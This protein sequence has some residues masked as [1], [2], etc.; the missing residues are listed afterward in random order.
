M[1]RTT[2]STAR[3][4]G[5]AVALIAVIGVVTLSTAKAGMLEHRGVDDI[6]GAGLPAATAGTPAA[7]AAS[8]DYSAPLGPPAR[9]AQPPPAQPTPPPAAFVALSNDLNSIVAATGAH[10]GI[11]LVELA[12]TDAEALSINGGDSFYAASEYKLP[13]LEY[14]AEMIAAGQASPDDQICFQD[15]DYIDG[16]FDDYTSGACFSRQELATRAAHYSDN[17]AAHMLLRDMGGTAALNAW[18]K[19]AGAGGSSFFEPNT[20]TPDDLAHLWVAEQSGELGGTQT[21][22]WL[23]PLLTHTVLEAGI[24]AGVPSNVTVVHKTGSLDTGVQNDAAVVLGGPAGAYVLVV[25]T[26]SGSWS[27]GLQIIAD[28]SSRVWA[29]ESSRS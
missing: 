23:Y 26:D 8:D 13:V 27:G 14:N 22:G 7:S 25:M 20:T 9:E 5:V 1:H 10:V 4:A 28:I 17:T 12:G 6:T 3:V 21:Q 16:W 18:A 24:P 29:Y 15:G 2:R 19:A 11:S